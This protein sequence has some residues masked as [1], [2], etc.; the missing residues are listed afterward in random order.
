MSTFCLSNF[1]WFI[2]DEILLY[3]LLLGEV[4]FL[5]DNVEIH[6]SNRIMLRVTCFNVFR[7]LFMTQNITNTST[8]EDLWSGQRHKRFGVWSEALA[9]SKRH[10]FLLLAVSCVEQGGCWKWKKRCSNFVH[11]TSHLLKS[12]VK[13][14]WNNRH[15]IADVWWYY[16]YHSLSYLSVIFVSLHPHQKKQVQLFEG[17]KGVC[18]YIYIF[19]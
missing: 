12:H 1:G 10:V 16:H 14:E 18:L 15:V 11:R 7:I 13:G 5:A 9:A 4:F 17:W 6:F 3:P 8:F 2:A 19:T